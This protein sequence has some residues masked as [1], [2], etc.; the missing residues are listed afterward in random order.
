M[1]CF[2]DTPDLD[3]DAPIPY[4]ITESGRRALEFAVSERRVG[5]CEHRWE[6]H[7]G[8]MVCQKCGLDRPVPRDTGIPSH[9]APKGRYDR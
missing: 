8:T 1:R 2:N 9:I 6:H 5:F 3:V 4:S 7:V